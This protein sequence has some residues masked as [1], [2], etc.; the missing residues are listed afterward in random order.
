V[1]MMKSHCS[2]ES[3]E[4]I[5]RHVELSIFAHVVGANPPARQTNSSLSKDIPDKLLLDSKLLSSDLVLPVVKSS[6]GDAS[7]YAVWH[8]DLHLHYPERQMYKP[9]IQISTSASIVQSIGNQ[10][11][12]VDDDYL[13]SGIPLSANLLEQLQ[14]SPHFIDIN[15]NLP[16]SR[17]HKVVPQSATAVADMRPVRSSS[18]LIPVVPAL[19]IRMTRSTMPERTVLCLEVESARWADCDVVVETVTG[20]L[21]NMNLQRLGPIHLPMEL[22]F[23]DKA[24]FLFGMP[25][26][27]SGTMTL[28]VGAQALFDDGVRPKIG[29]RR[30]INAQTHMQHS[31]KK[32]TR[33][34]QR[35]SSPTLSRP[36]SLAA[37]DRGIT[38]TIT[39]PAEVIRGETFHIDVFVVSRS[40]QKRRLALMATT[41]GRNTRK[42][43]RQSAT[44]LGQPQDGTSDIA[45][46]VMDDASVYKAQQSGSAVNQSQAE[47]VSLT[48]DAKVGPLVPGSCHDTQLEFLALSSGIVGLESL[49]V[50]DLDSR[51]AVSITELPDVVALDAAMVAGD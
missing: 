42:P 51:E 14:Y 19:L 13:P 41:S 21:N 16:A 29:A 15:V 39:A 36:A 37:P 34:W 33:H 35:P 5:L 45:P 1:V 9:A 31:L 50:V 49:T 17:I 8:S 2:C 38:F 20:L 30:R 26:N 27:S 46:A 25:S 6:E 43:Q 47:I 7:S 3:L 18:Q 48:A 32:I 12:D 44:T 10:T 28:N 23:G 40:N 4:E 11:V 24:V 22:K